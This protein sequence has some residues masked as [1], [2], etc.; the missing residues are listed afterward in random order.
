MISSPMFTFSVSAFSEKWS[1]VP[2]NVKSLLNLYCASSPRSV[3]RCRLKSD[4]FSSVTL[5]FVPESM[6]LWLVIVTIPML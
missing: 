6:M 1:S 3:F 2:P 4:W 5:T